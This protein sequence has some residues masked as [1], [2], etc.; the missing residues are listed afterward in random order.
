MD[1]TIPRWGQVAKN[2][3]HEAK[4]FGISPGAMREADL[5]REFGCI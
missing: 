4:K 1:G 2:L 3:E 5:L